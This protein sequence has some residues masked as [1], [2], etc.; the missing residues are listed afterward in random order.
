[1]LKDP[2]QHVPEGSKLLS[3]SKRGEGETSFG[4]EIW[5]ISVTHPVGREILEIFGVATS[6]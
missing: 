2:C 1:M 3:F 4:Y 5:N 6:I